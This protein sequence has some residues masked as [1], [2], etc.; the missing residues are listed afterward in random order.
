MD[1]HE[2]IQR[3]VDAPQRSAHFM[4]HAPGPTCSGPGLYDGDALKKNFLAAT[5]ARMRTLSPFLLRRRLRLLPLIAISFLVV[6]GPASGSPDGRRFTFEYE[7]VVGPI[8]PG[9]GPI[10]IFVPL[11]AESEQQV[12]LGEEISASIEGI[13]EVEKVYGNRYWHGSLEHG[14]GEPIT[15]R[16]RT[17]IERRGASVALPKTSR[18]ISESER[19]AL[20]SFLGPNSRV[21]VDHPILE[22]IRDEIRARAN[23]R[24]PVRVSRAIYDWVI[25]NIKYKKLGTGWGNGDTHWACNARFGNCTDFHALFIS[26]ARAEGIP[27]RFEIGFP[28]PDDR[29]MGQIAGYHCWVE[30]YIPETGWIP[31]DASEAFNNPNKK[32]FYF[33]TH[34]KDRIHFTTGRDLELGQ[35]H[36][37]APLNYFVYPHIEVGGSVWN[38]P[39]E[40]SFEYSPAE[41]FHPTSRASRRFRTGKVI[42]PSIQINGPT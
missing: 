13:V 18:G 42:P 15:I 33:G 3:K 27:A 25:D 21:V 38:G 17:L 4:N 5:A 40:K 7:T 6:S 41:N 11:A 10:H 20:E 8:A 9:E 29:G 14:E 37:A 31:I 26:L 16:V 22:P 28:I 12:I 35:G 39:I 19:Q 32:D 24:D 2:R 1:M 34:S 30:F 23:S 36:T